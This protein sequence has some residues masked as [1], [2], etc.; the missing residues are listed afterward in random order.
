MGSVT[1]HSRYLSSHLDLE[2]ASGGYPVMRKRPLGG[3][4]LLVGE[5]GMGTLPLSRATVPDD[6]A[7]QILSYGLDMQASLIDTAP[8][9]GGGRALSLLRRALKDRRREA[10]ICLKAGYHA[11][12]HSDFSPAG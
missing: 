10:Q 7:I 1:N 2:R 8:T 6:E 11:D 9:Y 3:T 12:G 4:G 5:V